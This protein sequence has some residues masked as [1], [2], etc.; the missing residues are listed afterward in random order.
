MSER[1]PTFAEIEDGTSSFSAE[2][3]RDG[4]DSRLVLLFGLFFVLYYFVNGLLIS[5]SD[6]FTPSAG[7]YFFSEYLSVLGCIL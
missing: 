4:L 5:D 2:A 7:I 6:E 1:R 3:T